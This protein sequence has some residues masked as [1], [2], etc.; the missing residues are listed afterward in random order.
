GTVLFSYSNSQGVL[1]SQ[2]GV[3]ST[4]PILS[5]RIFVN[6]GATT[7]GLALVNNSRQT[8]SSILT[9]RDAAGNEVGLQPLVLSGGQHLS[10]YVHELFPNLPAGSVGSLTIGS[11]HPLVAL[12]LRE[13]RNGFG[14]PLYSTLPV[15]DLSVSSADPV[16]FPHIA[17]GQGYT[18]QLILVNRSS[19]RI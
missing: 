9:L 6:E 3:G 1:V 18:T 13:S 19:Q 17:A 8:A 14:D 5:S 10:R 16:V 12:T 2:A 4:D 15:I 11:D 7:T